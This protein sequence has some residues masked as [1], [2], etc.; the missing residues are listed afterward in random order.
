MRYCL[1]LLITMRMEL[2]EEQDIE[3][4]GVT[5]HD[6]DDGARN[7]DFSNDTKSSTDIGM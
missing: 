3:E 5:S 2:G 4:L 6:V 7:P 1:S